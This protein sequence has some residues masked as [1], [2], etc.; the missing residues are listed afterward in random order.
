MRDTEGSSALVCFCH[1]KNS[2]GR[3][4]EKSDK[5]FSRRPGKSHLEKRKWGTEL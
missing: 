1:K 2:L 5:P 3:V 4:E